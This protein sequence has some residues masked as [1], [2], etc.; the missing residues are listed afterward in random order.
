LSGRECVVMRDFH[1]VDISVFADGSPSAKQTLAN[2]VD[3]VCRETGFLAIVG[4]GVSETAIAG[5]SRTA[6][7]FFDLPLDKKLAVKMPYVGYPYG[8]APLQTE[9][10]ARSLGDETPPDLKESFSIGPPNRF[11]DSAHADLD[12]RLAPNLWP[13][14]PYELKE[15]WSTYYRAVSELAARLMR[16][17]AVALNLPEDFFADKID[18]HASAM[19]ALNYPEQSLPPKPGQLRAGAHTDYGSVTILLAEPDPGGLE[20][21]TPEE[22]WVP[23]PSVPG[24]F[25]VNIGDLLARW[26][27]DRWVS[28]LHRVVF[29]PDESGPKQRQSI[30]FFHQPNWDA[31]IL[32]LPSCLAPGEKAKYPPVTSGVHLREKFLRGLPG[33]ASLPDQTVA[34]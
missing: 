14:E 6:Q 12:F 21:Y 24:G 10:L 16:I 33:A 23:I 27:N 1:I 28:T 4:H 3:E 22:E 2:R 25:I 34:S 31:E 20:I 17:L 5:V 26:T 11:V 18:R 32:C 15:A 30:A 9:A 13:A 19:R 8:Y 29:P 7:S